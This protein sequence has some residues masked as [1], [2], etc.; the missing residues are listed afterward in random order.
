MRRT[1]S[2]DSAD[3]RSRETFFVGRVQQRSI[4]GY[5]NEIRVA[6]SVGRRNMNGVVAP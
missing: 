1:R 2:T 6:H 4:S 5:D 3:R